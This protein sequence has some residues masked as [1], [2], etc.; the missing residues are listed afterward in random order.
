VK[1]ANLEQL[2]GHI[3]HAQKTYIRLRQTKTS[4]KSFQKFDFPTGTKVVVAAT[5]T[6]HDST[7]ISE[8][9]EK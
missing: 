3:H 2:F 4:C 5:F 9:M 6:S 1:Y 8:E 7:H